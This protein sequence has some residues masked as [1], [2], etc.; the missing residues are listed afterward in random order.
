MLSVKS[1]IIFFTVIV[2]FELAMA[3]EIPL[4][5]L[6]IDHVTIAVKDLESTINFFE[7]LG[8]TIK[9][10]T[11]HENSIRNAHIKFK[12]GASIELLTATKKRDEI[13]GWYVDRINNFPSGSGAFVALRTDSVSVLNKISKMLL[14]MNILFRE[15]DL[16]YSKIVAF[17]KS[18]PLH[19]I[20]FI[21][22][23]VNRNEVI[24]YTNHKN[25]VTKLRQIEVF[26]T[27]S[28]GYQSLFD[29]VNV[30]DRGV[31]KI[32]H[33]NRANRVH[34]INLVVEDLKNLKTFFRKVDRRKF[35]ERINYEK[36]YISMNTK[37]NLII[38]F[39]QQ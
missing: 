16:G 29:S 24:D 31:L 25:G 36:S 32:S 15:Y 7:D 19:S 34:S 35:I 17:H 11:K 23:S 30:L 8:F 12:N 22:Y 27:I 2:S 10:G 18:N 33:S 6:S 4:K 1:A 37:F 3:Q 38:N 20:F 5:N 26:K 13:S 28:S 14:K 21:N 9:P 39:I